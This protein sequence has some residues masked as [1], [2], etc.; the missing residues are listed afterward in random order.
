MNV[1]LSQEGPALRT[2][3][4]ANDELRGYYRALTALV[5]RQLGGDDV[6]DIVAETFLRFLERASGATELESPRA[7]LLSI[8][9]NLVYGEI[10]RRI[11][12]RRVFEPLD[13]SADES[14]STESAEARAALLELENLLTRLGDLDRNAFLLRKVDGYELEQIAD[15]L[16]ISRSTTQR[17]VASAGEFL[18]RSA[19][20]SALLSEF[21]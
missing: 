11:R 7:Y 18:R 5:S 19:S 3:R 8:A 2:T 13:L 21:V 1:R 14:P 4:A 12:Q 15:R 10:R 20:R 6:E 9:K 16:G 17:R